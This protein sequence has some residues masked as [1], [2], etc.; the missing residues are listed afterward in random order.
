MRFPVTL[1][2]CIAL[3]CSA[4]AQAQY[5]ANPSP[6]AS[7]QANPQDDPEQQEL[8]RA[9]GEAGNSPVDFVR[10]LEQ[11]LKKYPQAKDR[12]KIE[13]ALVAAAI[14]AKDDRRVAL[15]GERVLAINPRDLQILPKV[16]AALLMHEDRESAEK[17]FAYAHA[18]EQE[19]NFTRKQPAPEGY[20]T[21]R[22]QGL[23]DKRLAEALKLE[24]CAQGIL[25]KTSDAVTL[26]KRG[27]ET[28]PTA[29]GAR[30][31]GRWLAAEGKTMDALACYADAFTLEDPDSTEEDR[32]RDRLKMG[33][34]YH[35]VKKS[36]K[37]LGDLILQA[38][39]RTSALTVERL[40][41]V[42]DNDPNV[43]AKAVL[44]F[45]LPSVKGE[46]L[47]MRSLKG[48]TVVVDFWATWCGPCRVQRPMYE[49][50]EKKYASNPNVVFLSLNTDEDRSKVAPFLASQNWTQQVYYDAGLGAMLRVSSIPT[51][52][53]L[54]RDGQI[55]SRMAGFIPE[56][57]VDM[58]TARIEETLHDQ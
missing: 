46:A 39:D 37:G 50:V 17:A 38:Y 2:G 1:A 12:D 28:N 31:W 33:E 3:V 43:Q 9:L 34:L 56:R 49:Q 54:N 55:V 47:K 20:S 11:H 22:W 21:F 7:Q 32:A 42:R 40:A 24:A 10:A 4:I 26:A 23:A 30:E 18:L 13:R 8:T 27:W 16:A 5:A 41:K 14:E 6:A 25:G 36:E 45:T 51:T 58:L 15:Y 29:A 53:V 57:F 35:K 48:K 44:D 19:L 52:I